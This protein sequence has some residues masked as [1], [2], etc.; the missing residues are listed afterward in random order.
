[1]KSLGRVLTAMIT[2]YDARG[3]VDV[4]EAVRVAQF[5][6]ERGNDGVV[7][8]RHDRR[9]ARARN[10][11]EAGALPRHQATRWASAGR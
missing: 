1:M 3:A 9:I 10:R 11:R 8:E 2:P 4:A 7:V 6:V 5:L